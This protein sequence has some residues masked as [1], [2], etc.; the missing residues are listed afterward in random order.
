M[1]PILFYAVFYTITVIISCSS[2]IITKS[3][4]EII[5]YKRDIA[6]GSDNGILADTTYFDFLIVAGYVDGSLTVNDFYRIATKYIDTVKAD[7]Q[8]SSVTFLGQKP[9]HELP[10]PSYNNPISKYRLLSFDFSTTKKKDNITLENIALYYD[11]EI[12]NFWSSIPNDKKGIDSLLK[13]NI[14]YSNGF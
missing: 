4:Y 9:F 8:V 7:R 2:N 3:K 13:L 6:G 12:I 1:R 11:K 10:Y 14:P 5:F